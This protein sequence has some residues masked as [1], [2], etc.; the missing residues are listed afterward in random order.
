M[1][2]Q[3]EEAGPY[4]EGLRRIARAVEHLEG[5]LGGHDPQPLLENPLQVVGRHDDPRREAA[6][7]VAL[8]V[9]LVVVANLDLVVLLMGLHLGRPPA[10][11]GGSTKGTGGARPGTDA[12]LVEERAADGKPHQEEDHGEERLGIAFQRFGERPGQ[13]I[14]VVHHE[15]LGCHDCKRRPSVASGK[16]RSQERGPEPKAGRQNPWQG[17]RVWGGSDGPGVWIVIRP[18]CERYSRDASV[19]SRSCAVRS[20]GMIVS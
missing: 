14:E 3:T 20:R 7:G 1:T 13:G 15:R 4:E 16:A 11:D 19:G 10:G 2:S 17:H 5:V 8:V 6:S 9:D 12:Q 18:G